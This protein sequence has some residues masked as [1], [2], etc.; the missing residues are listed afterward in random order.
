MGGT[1][2]IARQERESSS[3][4]G[5]KRQVLGS[6]TSLTQKGL[7]K[8]GLIARRPAVVQRIRIRNNAIRAWLLS[9]NPTCDRKPSRCLAS[10]ARCSELELRGGRG[11]GMTSH[12]GVEAVSLWPLKAI[13]AVPS[14]GN[15]RLG[16][17][18]P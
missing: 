3:E 2:Q 13:P 4:E 17:V 5:S 6:Q 1:R 12:E 9:F 14:R 11:D 16:L 8:T 15:S 18:R 7:T 10:V